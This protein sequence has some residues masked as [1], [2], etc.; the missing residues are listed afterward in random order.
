MTEANL[1]QFP[2][3]QVRRYPGRGPG[4]TPKPKLPDRQRKALCSRH[5]FR[6]RLIEGGYENRTI[7]ELLSHKD[8]STAM[9]Y[10]H[11]LNKGGH[12]VRS[13]VDGL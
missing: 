9:I 2:S 1:N 12:G 7:K 4:A 3:S 8:I 13:P 11:V 5:S 6:T 10:A